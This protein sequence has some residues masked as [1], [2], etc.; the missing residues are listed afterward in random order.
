MT[1]V[2]TR[3]ESVRLRAI[4]KERAAG[5]ARMIDRLADP[6]AQSRFSD[7]QDGMATQVLSGLNSAAWAVSSANKAARL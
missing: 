1:S 7:R 2:G 6:Q 3:G 5:E 4:E